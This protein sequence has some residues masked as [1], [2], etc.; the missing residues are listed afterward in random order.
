MSDTDTNDV[1]WEFQQGETIVKEDASEPQMPG[2]DSPVNT[3]KT[4]Y[5]ITRR[6]IDPDE[7]ERL[8][9]LEWEEPAPKG[10]NSDMN[11]KNMLYS[12]FV[13]RMHYRL[14]DHATGQETE[15][16]Q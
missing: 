7:G 16:Q 9:Y 6:L 5:T 10:S 11:T 12:A 13:V 1:E 2:L 14:I 15:R 4:E 3:K 8:Y